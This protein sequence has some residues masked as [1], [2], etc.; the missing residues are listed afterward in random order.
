VGE[1]GKGFAVV[2]SEVRSLAGRSSAAAKEIKILVQNSV[3]KVRDGSELVNQSG[4]QLEQIVES[5]HNV[6]D[7]ISEI[8]AGANEQAIGSEEITK[9]VSQ[10][11][12][13]TQQNAALV[14]E[15]AA[16]SESISHQASQLWALVQKFKI[17]DNKL[18]EM[19]DKEEVVVQTVSKSQ[20]APPEK[21]VVNQSVHRSY[22]QVAKPAL[23][24]V[25]IGRKDEFEEF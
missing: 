24:F 25:D 3:N 19:F 17:D 7:I 22:G 9:A 10:M 5:V 21:A 4:A 1:Q 16:A 11:E 20:E 14:E 2:A 12:E 6:A 15:A 23:E 8:S 18:L 13:I